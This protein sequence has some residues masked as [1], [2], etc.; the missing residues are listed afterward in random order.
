M[1]YLLK[2]VAVGKEGGFEMLEFVAKVLAGTEF[3]CS[4]GEGT[5]D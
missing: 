2:R 5:H 3:K 4:S 1:A